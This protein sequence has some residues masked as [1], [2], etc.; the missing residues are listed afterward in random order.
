M[1]QI[2][3]FYYSLV[4]IVQLLDYKQITPPPVQINI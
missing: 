2:Y 4:R 1:K 3:I